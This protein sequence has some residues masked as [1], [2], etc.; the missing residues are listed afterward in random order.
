MDKPR[1]RRSEVPAYLAAKHRIPIANGG[2]DTRHV[3]ATWLRSP[4]SYTTFA[5]FN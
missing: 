3:D 1:L 4:P 5:A 2:T